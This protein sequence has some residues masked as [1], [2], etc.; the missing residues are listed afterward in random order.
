[1]AL[2]R[3]SLRSGEVFGYARGTS[4]VHACMAFE[5]LGCARPRTAMK[6]CLSNRHG[7]KASSTGAYF[8]LRALD[9]NTKAR[10]SAR[11][12]SRR[13]P[14]LVRVFLSDE[15]REFVER[16]V[17]EGERVTAEYLAE[18]VTRDSLSEGSSTS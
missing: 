12:C 15:V 4:V 2:L 1:M 18:C 3:A 8:A 16:R 6:A 11:R 5:A 10:S 14:G 13:W 17:A 7:S 9:A